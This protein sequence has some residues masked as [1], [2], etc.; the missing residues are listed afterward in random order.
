MGWIRILETGVLS[1]EIR[2]SSAVFF[3]QCLSLWLTRVLFACVAST[4]AANISAA[5]PDTDSAA[6]L[7]AK[8]AS[9]GAQLGRN[10]FNRAL[11]LVSEESSRDLKGDIYALVNYPFA[12][13]SAAL[14]NP[15]TWC[16]VLILHI[17]TKYCHAQSD[18][19]PTVLAVSM[20]R[21]FEQPLDDA[22][23]VEFSY[24][25]VAA[26]PEFLE[27]R[28]DAE[29]GP[30]STSNYRI[31]LEAVSVENERTFLHLTYSYGIGFA[32]RFAMRAYLATV[33]HGKVGF[34]IIGTQ[35]NGQ[36]DY[37]GGMRGAIE[38]NTM[39]YLLAIDAYLS[40]LDLPPLQQLEK[41]LDNWFAFTDQYSRQL[42]EV[43]R[44]DYLDMKRNEYLRQQTV[45]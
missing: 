1:V 42:H 45:Q 11:H 22:Y 31:R 29:S 14:S 33:G 20:G 4:I 16:D 32:G 7:H 23:R 40:A 3:S 9:L 18:R 5:V 30:M 10:Q 26:T 36:P 37:I 19:A 41:R 43:E 13:A 39:R 44:R 8:Y 15:A 27:A 35:S 17:N 12:K 34:T 28:L 24:R 6:L 38:R 25:V 2:H 21:K